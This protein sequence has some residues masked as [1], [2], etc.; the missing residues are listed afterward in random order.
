[1][2]F[3]DAI[4]TALKTDQ[5]VIQMLLAD[6]TDAD[7]LVR[8]VPSANHIAW[9]LGHCIT[10]EQ[11]IFAKIVPGAAMPT[12]P[13][14]FAE[15]H[16]KESAAKDTGFLTKAAYLDLFGKVRKGSLAAVDKLTDADLDKPSGWESA[17]TVGA[18]LLL[19]ANHATMHSGQFSVVRRKLGKPV[20]F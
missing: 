9:Q 13:S 10:S 15:Q 5:Q 18:M 2:N 20:V 7:L 19:M 11:E 17:P 12:L 14:G 1:M 4:R 3:Q 8:P 6:L 16:T